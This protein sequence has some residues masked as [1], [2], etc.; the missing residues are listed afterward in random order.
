MVNISQNLYH[1]HFSLEKLKLKLKSYKPQKVIKQKHPRS[2]NSLLY[3]HRCLRARK[4]SLQ[5]M[6]KNLKFG[7]DE[8]AL[9][10]TLNFGKDLDIVK[11]KSI[12]GSTR[13]REIYLNN[14]ATARS[15]KLEAIFLNCEDKED[16]LS[17]TGVEVVGIEGEQEDENKKKAPETKRATEEAD[18]FDTPTD[19]AE[20]QPSDYLPHLYS[21]YTKLNTDIAE[22][23]VEMKANRVAV[24]DKLDRLLKMME[25]IDVMAN[26]P[27]LYRQCDNLKN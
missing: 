16:D 14:G 23:K 11:L 24:N 2:P 6:D 17:S 22:L 5:K 12:F 26:Q 19:E 13:L 7:L 15:D 1:S 3:R 27:L 8:F 9:M 18:I 20:E 10:T 21:F 25:H 4:M